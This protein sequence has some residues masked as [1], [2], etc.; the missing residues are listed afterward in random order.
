VIVLLVAACADSAPLEVRDDA[1]VALV[2]QDAARPADDAETFADA[3]FP[4]PD[5][6]ATSADAAPLVRPPSLT[7]WLAGNAADVTPASPGPALILMGGGRDV[8]EAYAWAAQ[9][10]PG[11]DAVI[12]RTSGADGYQDYLFTEIGGFDSVETMLF[13]DRAEANDPWVMDRVRHAELIYIAGG[14]QGLHLSMWSG[15]GLVAAVQEAWSHGATIG[16]T[17]A[18]EMILGTAIYSATAGTVVSADVLADPLDRDVTLV[19]G[20][21]AFPPLAGA[22]LD[23]HFHQRDRFGRMIVFLLRAPTAQLALG[24]DENTALLVGPDGSGEVVGSGAVY[25]V[26][27]IAAPPALA[28]PLNGVELSRVALRR[29]EKIALPAATSAITPITVRVTGG[30]ISPDPY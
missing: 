28:A 22:I 30:V 8:D 23:S 18:G 13:D 21:F 29:G 12:L 24:I 19:P 10:V 3:L 27:K 15:T 5:A 2:F 1:A 7:Y 26:K 9:R 17:S 20:I 25:A 11:G 4:D 6:E 16:G 14:D